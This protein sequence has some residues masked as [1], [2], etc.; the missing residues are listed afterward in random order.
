[1]TAIAKLLAM[2][3][4]MVL[5]HELSCTPQKA[6]GAIFLECSY[7]FPHKISNRAFQVGGVKSFQRYM[8]RVYGFFGGGLA[9]RALREAGLLRKPQD[10]Q[11]FMLDWAS[12]RML[13]G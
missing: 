1:M 6:D 12:L 8:P 3:M 4:L 13:R 11:M 7:D 10:F 5:C 2:R 9:C